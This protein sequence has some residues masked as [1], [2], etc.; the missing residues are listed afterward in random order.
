MPSGSI[1]LLVMVAGYLG[2][3]GLSLLAPSDRAARAARLK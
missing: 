1:A 2:G 3:A